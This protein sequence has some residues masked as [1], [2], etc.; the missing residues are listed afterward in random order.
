MFKGRLEGSLVFV[1]IRKMKD[2]HHHKRREDQQ[3]DM[4]NTVEAVTEVHMRRVT[5]AC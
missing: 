4:V 2:I 3:T 5:P 1:S